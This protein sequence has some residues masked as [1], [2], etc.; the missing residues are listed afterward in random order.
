[1]NNEVTIYY[2]ATINKIQG[3]VCLQDKFQN[4]DT[5]KMRQMHSNSNGTN[6]LHE[7]PSFVDKFG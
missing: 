2:V 4:F 6:G 1:M 7:K 5:I 3:P